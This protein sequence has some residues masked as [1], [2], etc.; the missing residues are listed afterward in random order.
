MVVGTLRGLFLGLRNHCAHS[1]AYTSGEKNLA[2][3]MR[4]LMMRTDGHPQRVF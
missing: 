2:A 3:G 1:A 4:K